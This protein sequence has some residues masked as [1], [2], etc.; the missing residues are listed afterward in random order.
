MCTS[1]QKVSDPRSPESPAL[2][3]CR[4]TALPWEKLSQ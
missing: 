1:Q 4:L 2:N 3:S